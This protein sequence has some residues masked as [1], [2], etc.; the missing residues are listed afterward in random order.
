MKTIFLLLLLATTSLFGNCYIADAEK[1]AANQKLLSAIV[2]E[3]LA[4][5]A[6]LSANITRIADTLL[7]RGFHKEAYA[8][9]QSGILSF[10][11]FPLWEGGSVPLT[12]FVYV[13]PSEELALPYRYY[14]STIHSHPITCAFAVLQGTLFQKNYV[15]AHE[16]TVRLIDE[17]AFSVGAGAVDD[18]QKPF[19]HQLYSKGSGATPC[20]S[21][22]VYGLPS[23]EKVQQSFRDT[24]A[25]HTYTADE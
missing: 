18:L 13:W 20:L 14:A 12:F 4:H 9:D 22:H 24:A 8:I 10:N 3:E 6:D 16:K 7:K 2:A 23:A 19:I 15:I 17:E 21:L 11:C 25:E 5:G 1:H